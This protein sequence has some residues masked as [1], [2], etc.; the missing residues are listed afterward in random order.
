MYR[1]R[2][3]FALNR[4]H[5]FL[6]TFRHLSILSYFKEKAKLINDH[7]IEIAELIKDYESEKRKI[8]HVYELDKV[9]LLKQ[10]SEKNFEKEI[11]KKEFEKEK[12]EA[13]ADR[14]LEKVKTVSV[15]LD[16]FFR[17]KRVFI[18][19]IHHIILGSF[20]YELS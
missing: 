15:V 9:Q 16:F 10:I 1:L 2:Y 20:K 11:I 6:P 14:R 17:N 8:K 3:S 18:C 13:E 19:N 7:K 4:P 12:A 5:S